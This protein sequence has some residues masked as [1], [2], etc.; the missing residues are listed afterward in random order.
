ME[1]NNIQYGDEMRMSFLKQRAIKAFAI[2]AVK[3]DQTRKLVR[4]LTSE[5]FLLYKLSINY[6]LIS[7]I[8]Y[9]IKIKVTFISPVKII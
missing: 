9:P 7:L 4:N 3:E 8:K 1:I 6:V 2:H 5:G